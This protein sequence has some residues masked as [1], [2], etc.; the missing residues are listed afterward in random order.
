ME[1]VRKKIAHVD[2]VGHGVAGYASVALRSARQSARVYF[3]CCPDPNRR[4]ASKSRRRHFRCAARPTE[5]SRDMSRAAGG[6]VGHRCGLCRALR[7][8]RQLCGGRKTFGNP[9]GA[10]FSRYPVTTPW[11][12]GRSLVP[13]GWPS[14]RIWHKTFASC[15]GS[16]RE[17][18]RRQPVVAHRMPYR[19]CEKCSGG[20]QR[21]LLFRRRPSWFLHV[22]KWQSTS[23]HF[24][25]K[26]LDF[27]LNSLAK[28]FEALQ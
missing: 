22:R 12:L 19:Q 20:G 1:K 16:S 23:R 8:G 25:S 15:P 17:R 11:S 14:N 18:L 2:K 13:R 27:V 26:V 5:A 7:R 6:G 24:T 9:L 3:L 21:L 4:M 10:L 28:H